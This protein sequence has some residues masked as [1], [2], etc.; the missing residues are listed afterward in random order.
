MSPDASRLLD[1]GTHVI[2]GDEL[3][4]YTTREGP[5][6][7][8]RDRWYWI[9]A[10]AGGVAT[11]WQ[12]VFRSRSPFGPYEGRRVLEQGNTAVNGP[13]QGAWVTSPR[14]EDWF[15]HFQDRGPYGRVVHLQP[16]GWDEDGW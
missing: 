7:Y 3:P 13:H 15:L 9:F 11:G 14:G 2:N 4:G 16:M 12:S 8:K 6:F 10:P 5:K 1:N